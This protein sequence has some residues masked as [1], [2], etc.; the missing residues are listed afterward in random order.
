MC[1]LV[2]DLLANESVTYEGF[3]WL[4]VSL[5]DD[6]RGTR[7]NLGRVATN[8]EIEKVNAAADD[9]QRVETVYD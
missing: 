4:V 9:V 5:R 8:G 3:V 7:V 1:L 6:T 2:S